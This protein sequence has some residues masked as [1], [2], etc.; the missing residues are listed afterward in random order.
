LGEG[1]SFE[2]DPLKLPSDEFVA[3]AVVEAN[4]I[5]Q[6]PGNRASF[7]DGKYVVRDMDGRVLMEA[8][9]IY[10]AGFH[11]RD[12]SGEIR[13]NVAPTV[14]VGVQATL[15]PPYKE[16]F[17]IPVRVFGPLSVGSVIGEDEDGQ[18][19]F[20]VRILIGLVRPPIPINVGGPF[21]P[22]EIPETFDP[23]G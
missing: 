10:G 13:S 11:Q 19:T 21:D 15:A 14:S 18:T 4:R 22:S 1:A 20:G 2:Q 23:G 3:E 9:V 17:S 6:A 8:T 12:L 7:E 16:Y 5:L